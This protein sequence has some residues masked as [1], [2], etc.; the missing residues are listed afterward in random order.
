MM[1]A[2]NASIKDP[3]TAQVYDRRAISSLFVDNL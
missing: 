2:S 1:N 3:G